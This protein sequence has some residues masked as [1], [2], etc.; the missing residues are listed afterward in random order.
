MFIINQCI[1]EPFG[2]N[3]YIVA[4]HKAG[5]PWCDIGLYFGV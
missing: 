2:L 1:N 4:L 5:V 3:A